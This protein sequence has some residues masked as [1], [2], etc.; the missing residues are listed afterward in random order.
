MSLTLGTE[1]N[2][3]I[4][5]LTG[6][7]ISVDGTGS[8]NLLYGKE[9]S[10]ATIKEAKFTCTAA[11]GKTT[12]CTSTLRMQQIDVPHTMNRWHNKKDCKYSAEGI[13][14]GEFATYI[15]L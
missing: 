6:S 8:Y 9:R 13:F 14:H 10:R 2:C 4:P 7:T 11:A 5:T 3:G 1:F 12:T 15:S